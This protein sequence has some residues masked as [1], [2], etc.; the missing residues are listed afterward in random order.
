MIFFGFG[1]GF[2]RAAAIVFLYLSLVLPCFATFT[3][4]PTFGNG[5]KVTHS[6]AD[7]STSYSSRALRVFVQSG[8][9]ILVGGHFTNP[10]LDMQR[11]GVGLV[12]FT[13]GGAVDTTFSQ[14]RSWRADADTTLSDAFPYADGSTMLLTE[15]LRVPVG[16]ATVHPLRQN[17]NGSPDNV[18]ASNV[19]VGPP[20]CTG[21]FAAR[22][23]QIALR[24]DGKILV[25]TFE[26]GEYFL[27]RLNSDGT[28]DASFGE[29]GIVKIVFNRVAALHPIQMLA[30]PDGKILIVGNYVGDADNFFMTRLNETGSRDKRFERLGFVKVPFPAGSDGEIKSAVLQADGKILVVGTIFSET[31][32]SIWMGRFRPNGRLDP[33][34]GNN[35]VAIPD[36]IPNEGEVAN[37]VIVSPEGKIRIAGWSG[38]SSF[39]TTGFVVARFSGSGAYEDHIKIQFTNNQG[40]LGFDLALQPDGKLVVV[41]QTRNPDLAVSGYLV[42]IARLIE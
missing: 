26:D 9:R 21:Q 2:K 34:F 4:D 25:L 38:S 23:V 7:S 8:G 32:V 33:E 13:P 42:A 5:G 19:A 6:F 1:I 17:P 15:I 27:Y 39:F 37:S 3:L 31:A 35:G 16:S 36:L 10:G 18:F 20:C 29:N 11:Y 22:P 12:G 41:G 30:L 28:R 40:T 24:G 14:V